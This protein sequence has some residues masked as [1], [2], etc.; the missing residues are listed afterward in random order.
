MRAW[1]SSPA[2]AIA[3]CH[4]ASAATIHGLVYEDRTATASRR[5]ASAACPA[6]SSRSTS[7]HFTETDPGGSIRPPRPRRPGRHRLGARARR[8][9]AR[10]GVGALG[11]RE[12]RRPRA[13]RGSPRRVAARSRSSSRPTPTC[14]RPRSTSAP[15]TSRWPPPRRPRSTRRPRSSRSSATSRRA[16]SP[17]S[18]RSSIARSPASACPYVPVPGNHDWYDGGAAW[19][20]PLRPR[21]LQLRPRRRPL[22]RVE[23]VDGGRTRSRATS[24]TSSRAS[25]KTMPIV[26]LT[27]A[28]PSDGVIGVLRKLG[29]DYVLTGHTHSNRVVDHDGVIELNTEPLADGRPRLHAGRLPRDH[30]RRRSRSPRTTARPSTQPLARVIAPARRPVRARRRSARSDRGGRARRR[31]GRRGRARRLRDADRAALG[32]RLELAR[33]AAG[34]RQPARTRSPSTATSAV[35]RARDDDRDD[36]GVRRPDPRPRAGSDWPQLGGGPMHTGAHRA[37]AAP[38]RSSRGG[39]DGRRP[40]ASTAPPVIAGGRV[41]VASPISRWR[42]RRHRRARSRDR[43]GA[44]ARA[45]RPIPVRGGVAVAGDTVTTAE[46]DGTVLALDAATGA[47]RWRYA[48][49]TGDRRRRPVRRSPRPPPTAATCGRSPAPR[50]RARPTAPRSGRPIR[51]PTASTAMLGRGIAIGG[52]LASA[53]STAW[54]GGV[55][56]WDR[57]TGE[58]AWQSRDRRDRRHQRSPVIGDDQVFVVDRGRQGDRARPRSGDLRWLVAL[59]PAGFDWGNATIGTPAYAHGVARRADALP[60]SRRA[61][62]RPRAPSCGVTPAC[63]ARC[64]RRTTAA[65]REAGLRGLARDHR[66]PRVGGRHHRASSPRSI[67]TPAQRCGT[68]RSARPCSP[69][70]R[71][72]AT[73]SSSRPTTA[74]CAR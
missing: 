36:R 29:V 72:P 22:R 71:S 44:L 46:I 64:A 2:L 6:R 56:A 5:R 55:I 28:P 52:G 67:S 10:P 59:D 35:G 17:R 73:S 7:R 18:S 21:Q 8:L 66:R 69:A 40:R 30:D 3:T 42:R 26:A 54:S 4:S 68:P 11:R 48:L 60:R 25:P 31:H 61:R 49:S 45:D 62:S 74:R 16:T 37:R 65:P 33:A 47:V 15:P 19:F 32:R 20:R 57:A 27:H 53:R 34:A 23:H 14:T 13:A 24:A 1:L 50:R 9:R 38:R 39:R 43:R 58:R 12:R 51:C 41:Y 70:S 63:P